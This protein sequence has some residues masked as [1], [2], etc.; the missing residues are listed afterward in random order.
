MR[1]QGSVDSRVSLNELLQRGSR[2]WHGV[3]LWA[4]DWHQSSHSLAVKMSCPVDDLSFYVILNA[5]WESLD[6]ALPP[7]ESD[8]HGWRRW[9][10]TSLESPNDIVDWAQAPKISSQTYPAMSRSVVVLISNMSNS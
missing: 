4:P 1:H 5:Y 7:I 8:D 9:I 2:T 3:K 10:D 6:F